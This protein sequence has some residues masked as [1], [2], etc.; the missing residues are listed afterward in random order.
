MSVL[1]VVLSKLQEKRLA[2]LGLHGRIVCEK[3]GHEDRVHVAHCFRE[4]FPHHCDQM[5][6]LYKD[7]QAVKKATD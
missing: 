2:D 4:G 5:M 3:C 6:V 1:S 7:D